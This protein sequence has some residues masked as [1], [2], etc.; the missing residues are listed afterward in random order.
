MLDFT[1]MAKS[2]GVLIDNKRSWESHIDK[3]YK[4][5]SAQLRV[6]KRMKFFQVKQLEDI[7]YKMFLRKCKVLYNSLGK[8]LSS[9]L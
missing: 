2:L 7:Y 3:L 1:D 8:L 6:L 4:S 9:P 5:C